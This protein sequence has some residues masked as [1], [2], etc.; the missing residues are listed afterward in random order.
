MWERILGIFNRY[1]G[2]PTPGTVM[3]ALLSEVFLF[4]DQGSRYA[5]DPHLL[6]PREAG[7]CA[8]LLRLCRDGI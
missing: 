6:G 2:G 1:D 3:G 8:C 7:K 5:F 4:G